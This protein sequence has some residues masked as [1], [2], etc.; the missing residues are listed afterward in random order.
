MKF[1]TLFLFC[2]PAYLFAL[3]AEWTNTGGGDWTD[4]INWDTDPLFPNN[5]DDTANFLTSITANANITITGIDITVGTVNFDDNRDYTIRTVPPP[6]P[7]ARRLFFDVSSGAA[8]INVSD[9]NGAGAHRISAA[10]VL[11]DSLTMTHTSVA[12]FLISGNISG[13]G[14]LTKAGTGTGFL[15]LSGT[16]TYMGS[17]N[18]TEGTLRYDT[19]GCIPAA[20]VTSISAGATLEI[21]ASISSG[22][23]LSLTNNGTLDVNINEIA[24]LSS[25]A[26]SGSINLSTGI[27]PNNLFEIIASSST[28]FSGDIALGNA[29]V[30]SNPAVGNRLIKSGTS[31]LTLTG[32]STY[33]SRTF[34]QNGIINVQSAS[35]LGVAG[36]NS[37]TYVQ[38]GAT[39]EI[40]NGINLPKTVRLN[41][42]GFSS[43]GAIHNVGSSNTISGPVTLGWSGGTESA[44]NVTI[45]VDGST[46]LTI[47]SIIDGANTLTKTGAGTL[48]FTGTMANTYTGDTFV[49]A[50]TLNLNKIAGTTSIAGDVSITGGLLLLSA[51]NQLADTSNMTLSSGTFNMNSNAETINSLTFNGGT[52]T[53]GGA[54]LTL[55]SNTTALSMQATTIA[56]PLSLTGTGDVLFTGA[57]GT[58]TLSGTVNLGGNTHT[59]NINDGSA[60]D[61]MLI[62]NT[63]SN[64][65]LTKTGLGTLTFTGAANTYTG[66]TTVSAGELQLNKIAG[67]TSIAGD[68]SINGGLLLL[69]AANQIADTSNMTLSSGTFNMNSNAETINSLTFNGGTLSQMGSTLTLLSAT[70]AL[71]MRDT[72]ISGNL[73]FTGGGDIVFD[74]TNNGTAT[75]SGNISLSL[76][77]TF[78]IADGTAIIDMSV[79]GPISGAA[80]IEKTGTGTLLLTGANSYTGGTT[81]SAGILQGDTNGLQGSI[82]NES[83]LIF[84]QDFNG[85]YAGSM[86]GS[87]GTLIKQGTG[88]VNLTGVNSV[89]GL[90]T[91]AEGTLAVN[92]TLGGAGDL[93]VAADGTLQGGGTISK[94]VTVF[95]TLAPGNN[96]GTIFLVGDLI[97]ASGSV[98]D[99]ELNPSTSDLVDITGSLTIQ[100]GA[101]LNLLLEPGNY[102]SSFTWTLV[103]TTTGVTGEF[104]TVLFSL[105]LFNGVVVYTPTMVLLQSS[106][107]PIFTIIN[108]GNAGAVAECIMHLPKPAG[109]DLAF[110]VN[111]LRNIPSV[112]NLK[113][114]VIQLQPSAFTSLS[115]ALQNDLYYVRNALYNHLNEDNHSCCKTCDC[116]ILWGTIFTGITSQHSQKEE[117]GF[118]STSPGVIL[119]L[120]FS[121]Q[122]PLRFGT[123]LGYTHSFVNWKQ[124]RGEADLDTVYGLVYGKWNCGRLS[125]Q[126]ALTGGYNFYSIDREI[127]FFGTTK[128]KRT[129]R[130]HPKG[131]ESAASI[132]ADLLFESSAV[133]V[134]PYV[135]IDYFYLY[136]C[137]FSESGAK[138][139]NLKL[140]GYHADLLLAEWGLELAHCYCS[141]TDSITPYVLI[142]AIRENRYR[143]KKEKASIEGCNFTVEGIYPSRTLLN[144]GVGLNYKNA[145]SLE[146]SAF[147]KGKFG[148]G[149]RDHAFYLEVAQGF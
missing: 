113:K 74:A 115:I 33:I 92:G 73:S 63:I 34:I 26:G 131:A 103:D 141:E 6:P 144:T 40:Q 39:L 18:I 59:F 143:G 121:T 28:T 111:E 62:S 11:N 50:G 54:T 56:G 78:N 16:N 60:S 83:Q 95:G 12:N 105:P 44:A 76:P 75:L 2:L 15:L 77:T 8:A 100:P 37:A 19:N 98:L 31:T 21:N 51:A 70:T 9:A 149:F 61:D 124:E 1:L 110:I 65:A 107:F 88:L 52:L 68:V 148:K 57:A 130:S 101:T 94:D 30:S 118:R 24:R 14:G 99:N 17:T 102:S 136:R 20:S 117:P 42:S 38:S 109:S 41:G 104:S 3:T 93:I 146:I 66:L 47:S 90:S 64:G 58:A 82:V 132:R 46:D 112:K 116:W 25:L 134:A 43:G 127:E 80:S 128:I 87:A 137:A 119:G 129:A 86:T 48:S 138:S 13:S 7:S 27:G 67:T 114:A 81:I 4:G 5:I 123:V 89:G 69:S 91:V 72:T 29:N 120:D 36:V 97:F 53:Q 49:N 142:G 84:N 106:F 35:A 122:C 79:T 45:Q 85:T 147:Y 135:S 139:L 108:S 22:N 71:S 32:A 145:C 23:A 55:Q 126:G 10:V 125:L 96:I 140:K 133:Q